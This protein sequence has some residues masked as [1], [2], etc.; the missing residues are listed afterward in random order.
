MKIPLLLITLTLLSITAISQTI[1][2]KHQIIS[3][4]PNWEEESLIGFTT[5]QMEF[6]GLTEKIELDG[7]NLSIERIEAEQDTELD[8]NFDLTRKKIVIQLDKKYKKGDILDLTIYYQTN[9]V[10]ETD[11]NN[12][13]G[14]LGEGVRY[15][16]PSTTEPDRQK[17]IWTV[18]EPSGNALWFPGNF[19]NTDFRTTDLYVTVEKPLVV[20]SNGSLIS[21][22]YK[23][24]GTRTFHWQT[25]IPYSSHL[26]SFVAGRFLPVTQT[27]EDIDLVS[28]CYPHEAD[29]AAA[30]IER[31]PD[32]MRFYSDITGVKYPY[33]RY[34]QVFVQEFAGWQGNMMTSTITENMVDDW[35]THKDFRWLWDIVESEALA[36]QWFGVSIVPSSWEDAWLTKAFSRHL[37]GLYNES[38]N[39]KEEYLS[40]QYNPQLTTYLND[41]NAGNI[42]P[43]VNSSYQ[44]VTSFVRSNHVYQ[45][46]ATVLHMLR[47]ELGDEVWYDVLKRF[48]S[49]SAGKTVS[50]NDFIKVVNDVSGRDMEWF[51]NQWVHGVGHPFFEVSKDWDERKE[52]L[53]L[54]VRQIQQLDTLKSDFPTT[55]YFK[56]K[57]VVELDDQLSEIFIEARRENKY[58]LKAKSNPRFVNF[59]FESSW[60]NEVRFEKSVEEWKEQFLHSKDILARISALRELGKA[61]GQETTSKEQQEDIYSAMRSVIL[62]SSS[63]WRLKMSTLWQLQG[64]LLLDGEL[65]LDTPTENMLLETIEKEESWVKS[66]AVWFLGM[67]KDPKYA[68]LYIDLFDDWSDRVTNAAAIALGKT[69]SPLAFDAL[70]ELQHKPSWKNQSLISALN[71][72]QWLEDQRGVELALRSLKN[73]EAKHWTLSTP[74][75]DHRLSASNTLFALGEVSK[76]YDFIFQQ[77]KSAVKEEDLNDVI[78]NAMQIVNLGDP[79]GEEAFKFLKNSYEGNKRN[80]DI[81]SNLENQFQSKLE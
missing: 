12:I 1:D 6:L 33:E 28:Y 26:T 71:G 15:F 46:G 42:Q 57:I 81:I 48:A 19:V 16:V 23:E 77:L 63:Y 10:N 5:L 70:L 62:S 61:A 9:W 54:T 43:I 21:T 2:V 17:Q 69:K 56:G 64:L 68:D 72:L 36:S 3:V 20:L 59:D 74:I 65:S 40:Y 14:S 60:V 80:L 49:T 37:S 30:T 32:M 78:Y 67:T 47:K 11:P 25:S 27:Y 55:K 29:A 50:T 22:E 31:L 35:V 45:H 34:S 13:W 76:G 73:N 44:D 18:G 24:N 7:R 79:R 58:I 41:W 39:S 38:K 8:Y 52:E 51:F 4:E 75:W 66:S 53:N